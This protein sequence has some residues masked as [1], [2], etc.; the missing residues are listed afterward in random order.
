M[1]GHKNNL[2]HNLK[3]KK[4]KKMYMLQNR[5]RRPHTPGGVVALSANRKLN[6]RAS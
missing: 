1:E 4:N 5:N 6:G 2:C 3:N